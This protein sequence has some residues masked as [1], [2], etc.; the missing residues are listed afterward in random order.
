MAART[1]QESLAKA[2]DRLRGRLQAGPEGAPYAMVTDGARFV[3]VAGSRN[4][5][6]HW[7]AR[8]LW[9]RVMRKGDRD[10][11]VRQGPR[12]V[13]N[14]SAGQVGHGARKRHA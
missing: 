7:M 3:L 9:S 12:S 14:F 11:C 4:V 2:P 10:R 8:R 5:F 6:A 13:K 1:R